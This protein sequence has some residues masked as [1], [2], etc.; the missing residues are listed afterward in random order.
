[1]GSSKEKLLKSG[2]MGGKMLCII[3]L[4]QEKY[5]DPGYRLCCRLETHSHAILCSRKSQTLRKMEYAV[6][7]TQM[8]VEGIKC[9]R[10]E[11]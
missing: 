7:T 4:L 6:A 8:F 3:L 11:K 5:W 1:M 9:P 10:F 2:V